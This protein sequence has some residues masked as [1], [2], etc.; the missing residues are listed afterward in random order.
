MGNR[1][2]GELGFSPRDLRSVAMW[3]PAAANATPAAA[4]L[5][6]QQGMTLLEILLVVGLMVTI[7]AVGI[8]VFTNTGKSALADD[9]RLIRQMAKQAQ[10]LA[11]QTGKVHRLRFSFEQGAFQ[12]EVCETGVPDLAE[13]DEQSAALLQEA[14]QKLGKLPPE[15]EQPTQPYAAAA[16]AAAL[17]GLSFDALTCRPADGEG[18]V[19]SSNAQGMRGRLSADSGVKLVS[20]SLSSAREPIKE[21]A[22][23]IRFF[24]IGGTDR[25]I[26]ELGL[27]EEADA[28]F[29]LVFRGFNGDVEVLDHVVE[30]R[31][32]FLFQDAE[33]KTV[34][35]P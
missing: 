15:W 19:K 9:A 16:R 3:N 6:R 31:D 12:I 30:R 29:S 22:A 35:P 33:G 10:L 26:V 18:L 14:M 17:A 4:S 23:G 11:A 32:E 7:M 5:R 13:G 25:A 24:P 27:K 1:G 21:G 34:T 8:G 20:L 2:A 28:V